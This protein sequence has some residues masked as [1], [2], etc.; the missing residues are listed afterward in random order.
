[1]NK[2]IYKNIMTSLTK[3][4]S[5]LQNNVNILY[6]PTYNGYPA[7]LE[8]SNEQKSNITNKIQDID[9][10]IHGLEQML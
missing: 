2:K 9:N 4:E 3:F 10:A 6:H 5:A 7:D 1:M 8:L